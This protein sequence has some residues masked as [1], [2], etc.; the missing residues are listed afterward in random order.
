MTHIKDTMKTKRRKIEGGKYQT[1]GDEATPEKDAVAYTRNCMVKAIKLEKEFGGLSEFVSV[2]DGTKGKLLFP[3]NIINLETQVIPCFV[4]LW[5]GRNSVE[6]V[7]TPDDWL[8]GI[9][10]KSRDCLICSKGGKVPDVEC[11][12]LKHKGQFEANFYSILGSRFPLDTCPE[13]QAR[14]YK[15]LRYNAYDFFRQL[16][17]AS[18]YVVN[19]NTDYIENPL[20]P[21]IELRLKYWFSA[22]YEIF[23]KY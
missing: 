3:G 22:K 15:A 5:L 21:C 10:E 14:Y 4:D 9:D 12:W 19:D 6:E 23:K 17:T 8:D 16:S 1:E 7:E 18:D 11:A 13:K 20:P 2:G